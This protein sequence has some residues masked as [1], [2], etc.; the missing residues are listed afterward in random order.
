MN[1]G[2]K[3]HCKAVC[4]KLAYLGENQRPDEYGIETL[5][6]SESEYVRLAYVKIRDRMNTG[7]KHSEFS[8]RFRGGNL[9]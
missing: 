8:L 2:L 4:H 7:L 3:Q 6:H 5:S 9:R 1:T